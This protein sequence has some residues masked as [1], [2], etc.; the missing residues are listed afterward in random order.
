MP[1]YAAAGPAASAGIDLAIILCG[2]RWR[3]SC[4][5]ENSSIGSQCVPLPA[6]VRAVFILSSAA[7]ILQG[8]TTIQMYQAMARLEINDERSTAARSGERPEHLL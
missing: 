2:G 4:P 6:A 8:Y 3:A 5:S 1:A 7:M